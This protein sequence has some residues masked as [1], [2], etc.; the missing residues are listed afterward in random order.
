MKQPLKLHPFPDGTE[1]L[2]SKL[3][4]TAEIQRTSTQLN[5][6]YELKGQVSE[7]IFPDSAS[8]QNLRRDNLWETTCFECFLGEVNSAEYWEINLAP[9]QS[10]NVYRFS[11]YRKGMT[12][13]DRIKTL[14][15]RS[16]RSHSKFTLEC[17]LPLESLVLESRQLE[18]SLTTVLQKQ[19][20][21]MGFWAVSHSAHQADFHQR[22]SFI[23]KI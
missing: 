3:E 19:N 11:E 23:I 17:C 8:T 15:S 13:E 5:L 21:E 2:W 18:L 14:Q 9:S 10:W 6:F 4:L 16:E 1:N 12:T 22:Q 20:G 7:I